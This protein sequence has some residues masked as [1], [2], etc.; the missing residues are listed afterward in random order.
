SFTSASH[1]S[2]HQKLHSRERPYRCHACGKGFSMSS[3]CLEHARS[4]TGE[5]PYHC[6]ECGS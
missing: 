3:K 1:L 2:V 6:S 4:H 5:G